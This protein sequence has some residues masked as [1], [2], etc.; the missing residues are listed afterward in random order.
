M[1]RGELNQFTA[2]CLSPLPKKLYCQ[3]HL[4]NEEK[5]PEERLDTGRLTR[6]RRKTLGISIDQLREV[7]CRK[8][9]AIT[10]S[11]SRSST[12]GMLYA[13][14][15]CGVAIGHIECIHAGIY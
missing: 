2:C 8:V 1:K 6:A 4:E 5:L 7:G 13:I 11:S 10:V 12:A 14:R 3:D 15:T 9:E